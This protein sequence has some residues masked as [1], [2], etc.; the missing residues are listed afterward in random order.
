M[1]K[2]KFERTKPHVNIGTIG[3]IDHG[4]TTLT[5]AISKV[6]H[7][8]YPDLNEAS[9]FDSIDKAPEERQRG[10]TISIAHIEYQ[11]EQRHYAHVD[12]PGHADYIKNMITGAAQMDGAILVVAATDGPMPQTREHVLLARQVGVPALVVALN[13]CDMVDDEELIELVE[14]EVRELL[15][16]YEFPGDDVPVVRVAAFPALN[17]DQKWAELPEVMVGNV[18]IVFVKGELM[19]VRDIIDEFKVG[20][21]AKMGVLAQVDVTIPAGPSGLDPS[22]TSFFQALNIPTKIV[23]GSI[24]ITADVKVCTEGEKV[25]ASAATLLGKMNIRPFAY[26]LGLV[27][28]FDNGSV[29]DTKVL[30]ITDEDIQ[31]K[32]MMGVRNIAA[33]SLAAG[34]PTMASVPHSFINGYKKV[35]SIALTTDYVFEQAAALKALL[36]DPEAM[37]AAMAAAAKASGGGGGAAAEPEPEPEE[38]EEEEEMEFDLFD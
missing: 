3:H 16:E 28:V 21:P 27:T 15:S 19:E 24:E 4:K 14:M 10:I 8:K 31:A 20:A 36:D 32:F 37:A 9:P 17:G 25:S 18:G 30:D 26:N 1:A 29:Y 38:E 23:K 7:D 12:C 34:Y 13:K 6:L 2:A 11:T 5:A 33:L 22:Q 35:L